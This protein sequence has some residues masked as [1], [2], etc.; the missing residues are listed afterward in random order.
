MGLGVLFG[1]HIS[2]GYTSEIDL[3]GL[4]NKNMEYSVKFEL[5]MNKYFMGHILKFKLNLAPVFYLA[6]LTRV[7]R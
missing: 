5:Q 3:P 4:T 7:T 2:T 6:T 1:L